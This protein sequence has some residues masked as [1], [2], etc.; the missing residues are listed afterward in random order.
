MQKPK[1]FTNCSCQRA[2]CLMPPP[3]TFPSYREMPPLRGFPV[4]PSTQHLRQQ[5]QEKAEAR[6]DF[7]WGRRQQTNGYF[8]SAAW[9]QCHYQCREQCTRK[10]EN[11]RCA[12]KKRTGGEYLLDLGLTP[13]GTKRCHALGFTGFSERRALELL[14]CV[15]PE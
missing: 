10:E 9:A 15:L 7:L 5:H 3:R 11:H 8:F 1:A 13:Y 14:K 2:K 6:T 4:L 12:L